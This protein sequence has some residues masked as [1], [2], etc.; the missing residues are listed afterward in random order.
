M[1][2]LKYQVKLFHFFESTCNR[3]KIL[4]QE[5]IKRRNPVAATPMDQEDI[6]RRNPWQQHPGIRRITREGTP[7]TNTHG[8]GGY[9]KETPG[10]YSR[11][12]MG[13]ES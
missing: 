11:L 10:N 5:S 3:L 4:A 9:K 6:K 13:P 1:F 7:G 12:P 8:S 2:E